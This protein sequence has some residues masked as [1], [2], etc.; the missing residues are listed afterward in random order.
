MDL[1]NEDETDAAEDGGEGDDLDGGGSRIASRDTSFL[2]P[3]AGLNRS[4]VEH[5]PDAPHVGGYGIRGDIFGHTASQPVGRASSP[6]LYSSA[7]LHVQCTQLRVWKVENGIPTAMGVIEATASEEDFVRHFI[8]AMPKPGEGKCVFKLRPI[9]INGNELGQEVTTIISEHHAVLRQIRDATTAANAAP[10][11]GFPFM[12]GAG[13]GVPG[14]AWDMMQ[15]LMDMQ[16]MQAEVLRRSVD[17]E[18][19]RYRTIQEQTAK[20]RVELANNAA[21]GVQALTERMMVDESRRNE[22]AVRMQQEQG[23]MLLTTLTS[24]FSQQMTMQQA[25]AEQAR[26]AMEARLEQERLRAE[27]EFREAEARRHRESEE[28]ERRLRHEREEAALKMQ[29]ERSD[30]E[31]RLERERLESERK[32]RKEKEDFERRER[33]REGE[34]ARQHDLRMKEM[35]VQRER[36]REHSER[37]FELRK[38]ALDVQNGSGLKGTLEQ[39]LGIMK[40]M[41]VEPQD[42]MDRLLGRN[43]EEE[44]EEQPPQPSPWAAALPAIA[45][46]V[47]E[48]LKSNN[49]KAAQPRMLPPP[50]MIPQMMP[51]MAGAPALP[52]PGAMPASFRGGDSAQEAAAQQAIE[53]VIAAPAATTPDIDLP[54][55]VQ[56]KARVAVRELLRKYRS[57][58]EAEWTDHTLQ[59]ISNEMSIY[60]YCQA[61]SVRYALV[62]GGADPALAARVIDL[63]S[64]NSLVPPDLNYG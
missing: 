5:L 18:R 9:D 1:L 31:A 10:A 19:D 4:D 44:D 39:G 17:E 15:R 36:D 59:A 61:V 42:L 51:P 25:Q 16:S 6:K 43:D 53:E 28:A 12:G 62:E 52:A 37:M 58:P 40:M 3:S 38:S 29:R 26:L 2:D 60:H 14:G 11:A 54:L 41:G 64:E 23:Q 50:G 30:M 34:R 27:R 48:V 21:S 63:L 55:P 45:G 13:M 46:V 49:A 57:T 47:A 20:E 32:E 8:S 33:E 56:R 35:E 24:I 7:A 22:S